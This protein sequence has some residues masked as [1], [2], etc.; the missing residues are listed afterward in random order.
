[1]SVASS[2]E[3]QPAI[4]P[5]QA[6]TW[7]MSKT[8][9]RQIGNIAAWTILLLGSIIFILPFFWMVSSSFK[10]FGELYIFPPVLVPKQLQ[11]QNYLEIW[12]R[13][14][15]HLFFRNSFVIAT[16]QTL[17][18]L[19]TSSLAGYAFS[20]LR[21][22]GRDQI[23][24]IY[25]STMM[26]PFAVRMIPL[27]ILMRTFGWVDTHYALIVPGI[28]SAWGTFLMRQFMMTIPRELEDAALIDGASFFQIYW[29]IILPLTGP[30][31]ATLGIFEFMGS[32]N[33]FLWPLIILSSMD[34][35][36]IALGL[37]AFQAMS[38]MKTP[39]HL[40][41]TAS[42]VSVLP[43]IAIFLAGQKYYV[44]GIVTTG[45]KG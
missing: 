34:N 4:R 43:I 9:Q 32:W 3:Q 30:A 10:T 18:V 20:R 12:R 26:I 29:R 36:T 35:K 42:V 1:M 45:L 2:A 16:C 7:G 37:A 31:L 14:P 19:F 13:L 8:R 41:M 44:R 40:V 33:D 39:W 21:F 25:L 6:R 23:F 28:F 15:F 5:K 11:W 17:G 22:P 38:A 24:L 27:F